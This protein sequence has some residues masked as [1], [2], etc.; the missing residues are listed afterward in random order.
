M[1]ASIPFNPTQTTNALGSFG[2]DWSGFIAGTAYA[3]P[4]ARYRL[5]GGLVAST[6]TYPMWGG[7]AIS[8]A[9]PNTVYSQSSPAPIGA[10]GTIISRATAIGSLGVAGSLTGFSVFDQN[11]AM[12]NTPQ[13]PVPLAASLMQV[14][15]YRLGSNARI[16]LPYNPALSLNGNIITQS[17]SWDFVNQQLTPYLAAWASEAITSAT[18]T[19]STGIIALTFGTAP[20]GASIGSGANGVYI[21]LSGLTTS[22]WGRIGGQWHLPG[23][24]NR[25]ERHGGQRARG[26]RSGDD[27][28]QWVDRHAGGGRRRRPG[29]GSRLR[30]R[31]FDGRCLQHRDR[32]CDVESQRIC[33]SRADLTGTAI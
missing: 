23:D 22:A 33:G 28:H 17:L 20:F 7:L 8:E 6:E 31:Q 18:Y 11:Y 2:V 14:N 10:L 13:S 24:G 9:T 12:I 3:D 25:F 15:F 19:S 32:R 4:S 30:R 1:T 5:A 29:Q 21:N 26:D 27:H 16:A